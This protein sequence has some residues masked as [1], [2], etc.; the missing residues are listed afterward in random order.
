MHCSTSIMN[1]GCHRKINLALKNWTLRKALSMKNKLN[2]Q[3]TS[4][5]QHRQ[6]SDGM[7]QKIKVFA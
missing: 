2:L 3:I 4:S 5:Q 1:S 7:K 6:S